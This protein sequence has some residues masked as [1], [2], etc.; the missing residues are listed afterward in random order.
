MA[1]ATKRRKPAKTSP[2]QRTLARWREL[3]YM[4]EVVERWNPH[5][6][7]RQ[8]LF[9]FIDIVAVGSMG[10]VGIQATTTDNLAARAQKA[11][12]LPA[13]Q[14]WSGRGIFVLEGWAKRGARGERKLWTPRTIQVE[15][16]KAFGEW[17]CGQ[18]D[19]SNGLWKVMSDNATA[20]LLGLAKEEP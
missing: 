18:R 14:Q 5:A 12:A 13:F 3:G 17:W 2:T 8:D 1:E 9:G 4:C 7:I 19:D 20:A 16:S 10:I 15:Y 6:K 11:I